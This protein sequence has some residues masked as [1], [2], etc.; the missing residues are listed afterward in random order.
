[1]SQDVTF[2]YQRLLA[3]TDR[4]PSVLLPRIAVLFAR[5]ADEGFSFDQ[6]AQEEAE[7]ASMFSKNDLR[8]LF[9][10]ASPSEPASNEALQGSYKTVKEWLAQATPESPGEERQPSPSK[11]QV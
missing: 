3:E 8:R 1:V 5:N 9:G 10:K 7:V 2:F 6:K 11:G 4:A